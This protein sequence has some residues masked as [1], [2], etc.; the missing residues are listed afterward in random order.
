MI[1]FFIFTALSATALQAM[2]VDTEVVSKKRKRDEEPT[3]VD[4]TSSH[5]S[6][7]LTGAIMLSDEQKERCAWAI[8]ETNAQVEALKKRG[9][10]KYPSGTARYMNWYKQG[11]ILA[12][13]RRV[14]ENRNIVEQDLLIRI[15]NEMALQLHGTTKAEFSGDDAAQA[16]LLHQAQEDIV[17]LTT[18]NDALYRNCHSTP[19]P[20]KK[21]K[22]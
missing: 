8:N 17:K 19:A 13:A 9:S 4:A 5:A 12:K 22:R 7:A 20:S 11:R 1:Y 15:A 3:I 6:S 18:V 16:K 2:D 10:L 14:A 21:Q